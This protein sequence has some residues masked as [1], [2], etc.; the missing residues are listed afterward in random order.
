M[1]R[2]RIDPIKSRFRLIKW[3]VLTA[4]VAFPIAAWFVATN[5]FQLT[6]INAIWVVLATALVMLVIL[7]LTMNYLDDGFARLYADGG[8]WDYLAARFSVDKRPTD[9]ETEDIWTGPSKLD[10]E[11]VVFDADAG[12]SDAGIYININ[13][14]GRILIPWNSISVLKRHRI[15]VENGWQQMVLIVLDGPEIN[16]SIPWQNHLDNVVPQS[17]GIS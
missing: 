9:I 4:Y 5:A 3:S 1:L 2:R 11:D 17:V 7:R 15:P 13:A 6:T 12:I 16:L 8:D 14:L 10:R